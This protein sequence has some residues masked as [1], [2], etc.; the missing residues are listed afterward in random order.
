MN[1]APAIL[2]SLAL[3]ICAGCSDRA[4]TRADL[5]LINGAEVG[6]IDPAR[7]S[8]QTEGRVISALFEGLMRY[9]IDGRAEPG[10][11]LAPTVSPDG[12]TYTFTIRDTARWSDG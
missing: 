2:A 10:C 4:T 1:S 5:V 6:T 8:V 11:A 9:T 12:R 7:Y 3:L